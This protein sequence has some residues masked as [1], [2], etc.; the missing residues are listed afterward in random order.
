MLFRQLL[1]VGL[2]LFCG[3][4]AFPEQIITTFWKDGYDSFSQ[5]FGTFKTYFQ[6]GFSKSNGYR[7]KQNFLF[8]R[9]YCPFFIQKTSKA[10]GI[11]LALEVVF[12]FDI[13]EISLAG[14]ANSMWRI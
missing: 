14:Y 11:E 12:S 2:S 13:F 9:F 8:F 5:K 4:E 10:I 1:I 6:V 3:C 7:S